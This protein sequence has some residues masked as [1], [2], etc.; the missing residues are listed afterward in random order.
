VCND[1]QPLAKY[2]RTSKQTI[3]S[4]ERINL[5]SGYPP[6]PRRCVSPGNLAAAVANREEFLSTLES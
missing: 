5:L 6:S 2:S 4:N 1:R 3:Q